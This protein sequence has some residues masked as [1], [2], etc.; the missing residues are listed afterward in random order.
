MEPTHSMKKTFQY[1][2]NRESTTRPTDTRNRIT[3]CIS[4]RVSYQ[5]EIGL[6]KHLYVN[7]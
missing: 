4:S 2:S 1:E 3:A 7:V 5:T 6:I